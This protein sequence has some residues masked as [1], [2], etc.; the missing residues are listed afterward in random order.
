MILDDNQALQILE[1]SKKVPAFIAQSRLEL[2]ATR[3]N[4]QEK[5]IQ[6]I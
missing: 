5:S 2:K 3:S 6:E 4:K 1:A